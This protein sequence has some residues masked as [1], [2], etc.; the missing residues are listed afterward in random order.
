VASIPQHAIVTID[1]ATI[2]DVAAVRGTGGV[3][4]D[5]PS[6]YLDPATVK[7]VGGRPAPVY[8]HDD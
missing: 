7:P 4:D 5:D 8:T 2:D 3:D 6:I 1:D